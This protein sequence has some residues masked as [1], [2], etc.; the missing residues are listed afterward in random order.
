[1]NWQRWSAVSVLAVAGVLLVFVL[2]GSP[3]KQ[4]PVEPSPA[5][6]FTEGELV[7]A[8]TSPQ[9][10]ALDLLPPSG[11]PGQAEVELLDLDGKLLA[12]AS[13]AHDGKPF[14]VKLTAEI[15]AD[16]PANYYV[17]YRFDASETFRQ[18]SLHFL[19]EV[20]ETR[21]L[22]QREF[23]AD[24]SPIVRI[25]VRDRARRES[26]RTKTMPASR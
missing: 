7:L 13:V 11:H 24:T 12:R 1:M 18:R 4:P 8:E 17:R 23:L 19:G 2:R 5:G 6:P 26:R 25:M 16:D 3:P 21:V 10:I 15:N 9:S 14:Q 20:L 22:G